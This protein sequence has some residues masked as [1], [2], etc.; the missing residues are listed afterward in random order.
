MVA[1]FAE[2]I[3][4][5][6]ENST[7]M[8]TNH[9]NEDLSSRNIAKKPKK[10]TEAITVELTSSEEEEKED[11]SDEEE[12]IHEKEKMEKENERTKAKTEKEGK[13]ETVQ[14]K[15]EMPVSSSSM[16]EPA[17]DGIGLGDKD[18]DDW[19]NS[20]DLDPKV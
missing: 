12:K 3:D 13:I 4:S 17:V 1:G 2:D 15:L 5:E 6:D 20:P 11:K 9:I 14:L 19:L 8:T 16:M 18:V 10:P 7:P